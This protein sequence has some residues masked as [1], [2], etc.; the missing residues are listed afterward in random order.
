M[1][2]SHI[3]IPLLSA[4]PIKSVN[5]CFINL[6]APNLEVYISET[7][8]LDEL[9]PFLLCNVHLCRYLLWLE[10]YFV[11]DEY[12]YTHFYCGYHLFGVSSFISTFWACLSSEWTWVFWRQRIVR[13]YFFN[14]SSHFVSVTGKFNPFTLKVITDKWALSTLFSGCS[15]F[16]LFL[17][18][19]FLSAI[20][21]WWFSVFFFCLFVSSSRILCVCSRILFCGYH[22]I[23]VKCLT[24][25]TVLFLMIA[26]YPYLSSVLFPLLLFWFCCPKLSLFML[27]DWY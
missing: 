19:E 22:E 13:T 23:C 12:G 18:P 26:L 10:V 11:S 6:G 16:P 9:S 4:S 1:L 20:L 21:V 14:L 2:K 25:R 3:F 17:F 24:D 8:L 15:V 27:W 5:N 7:C